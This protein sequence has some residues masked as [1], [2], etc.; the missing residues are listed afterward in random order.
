MTVETR[1]KIEKRIA[2]AVIKNAIGA[3]YALAVD[4]GEETTKPSTNASAVLKAMFATDEEH[5]IIYRTTN[6]FESIGWVFLVYGN[7][8]WDVISDYTVNLENIIPN[9]LIDK[10]A[11]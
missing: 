10:L 11:S 9:D 2:R 1:Q 8:G 4:N 5:L 3:G 7:D 6:G